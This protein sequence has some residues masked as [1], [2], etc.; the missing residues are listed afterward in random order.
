M[1]TVLR[2]I[3]LLSALI[4]SSSVPAADQTSEDFYRD[5]VDYSNGQVALTF[6][7]TPLSF[8]LYAI[9]AKTGL[10]IIMPSS[11]EVKLVNLKLDRQPFEPAMRSFISTMG[12]KNFALMY[13][14][15][16]RPHRAVV[17]GA[18]P[19]IEANAASAKVEPPV[20]PLTAEEREKL[21]TDLKRWSELKQE[22]RGR[23]EDRIK[24]LPSSDE[25]EELVKEF[26]RQVLALKN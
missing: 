17:L 13:D 21:Q 2:I 20:E 8:A 11:S 10:Q 15:D 26:G 24:N 25:R 3:P 16:G 18:R 6:Y 4:F 7:Q 23:I 19:L 12:Y 22:E 5:W 1:R 14:Q 9:H